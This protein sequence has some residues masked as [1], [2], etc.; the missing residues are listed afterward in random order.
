MKPGR[1]TTRL[2]QFQIAS[3]CRENWSGMPGDERVRHCGRCQLNVYNISE[4]TEPEAVELTQKSEGRLCIRLFRR[5]DGTVLTRDCPSRFR[6]IRRA[7][8][9]AALL[10]RLFGCAALKSAEPVYEM[11]TQMPIMEE[12][13]ED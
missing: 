6:S 2:A 11:G 3:P 10:L 9:A 8:S 12:H 4:L 1:A 7:A 13:Q 5:P